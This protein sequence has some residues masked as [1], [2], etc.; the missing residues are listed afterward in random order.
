LFQ[1]AARLLIVTLR[2]RLTGGHRFRSRRLFYEEHPCDHSFQR[3]ST[4]P[5]LT[6]SAHGVS[7]F[8]HLACRK[9][10]GS[11]IEPPA[12]RGW[13]ISTWIQFECSQQIAM[14]ISLKRR[15]HGVLVRE[16]E[17]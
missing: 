9:Q 11:A 5:S 13:L 4:F 2:Q 7:R 16:C 10:D 14:P 1:F 17:P 6:R 8:V 3:W 15:G 12:L